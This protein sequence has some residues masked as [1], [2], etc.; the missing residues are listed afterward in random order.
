LRVPSGASVRF[1]YTKVR[2]WRFGDFES[3]KH[4]TELPDSASAKLNCCVQ[5]EFVAWE[6]EVAKQAL[7][8]AEEEAVT[9]DAR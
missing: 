9:S 8:L 4:V 3:R 1:V 2:Y 7:G 5:S 6:D